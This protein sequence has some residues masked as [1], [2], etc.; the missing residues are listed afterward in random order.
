MRSFPAPSGAS[1]FAWWIALLGGLSLNVHGAS[2]DEWRA[3]SIYQIVTDRF[4][5]G[6]NSPAGTFV[7]GG[8]GAI[9]GCLQGN[10]TYC[11]GTWRGILENLDYI[12]GMNFDAIWISPVVGQLP[13]STQDG[14]A[15]AGYW[16]QNVYTLNSNFGNPQDLYDLIAAVHERGMYFM[17]DVVPNHMAYNGYYK[18]IDYSILYPFN[19]SKYYHPYCAM[20]Y[21]GDNLTALEDCWLGSTYTPL[22]DLNTQSTEVQSMWG[23]WISEMVS[24]Y[25]VDGL[26][27]DAGANVNPDFFTG[28]V[29]SAGVFATAEVYLSNDTVACGWQETV[30]SILNYPLYWKITDAF[31]PNGDISG[32]VDMIASEKTTCKDT[33]ALATFSEVRHA[34]ADLADEQLLTWY[35]ITTCLAFQTIHKS[36]PS[37]PMWQ[38]S[39]SC[40]TAYPSS[41]TARNNITL[42]ELTLSPTVSRYGRRPMAWTC[43][44]PYTASWQPST[45][46][47]SM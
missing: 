47:E 4:S 40:L 7:G 27:I 21:S 12:Q 11:G 28:F 41:I 31:Q 45:R 17:M 29:K 5:P 18:D 33:T 44:L 6:L 36:S 34:Q 16:Q 10:G 8:I 42:A 26:R 20:D 2:V 15:Y 25:S 3:R 39:T 37:L 24:N 38:H 1:T 23:K 32:L 19:D 46:C 43:S 14:Q 30:G 13:Q 9:P 22:A 35:R